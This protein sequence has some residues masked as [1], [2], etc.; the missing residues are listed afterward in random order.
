MIDCM[1]TKR[2]ARF[3]LPAIPLLLGVACDPQGPGAMGQLTVSADVDIV[4]GRTL[5]LRAFPDDGQPFDPARANL[6]DRQ[7][8]LSQSMALTE[9]GVPVTYEILAPMGYTDHERWRLVAWIAE[10]KDANR[11]GEG[12]WYGTR[13]FNLEECGM[14]FSGYCGVTYEVDIKIDQRY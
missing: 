4:A 7:W 10:S 6:S 14:P 3:L 9:A 5:E 11:P 8:L 2:R 13:L 12:E 1:S